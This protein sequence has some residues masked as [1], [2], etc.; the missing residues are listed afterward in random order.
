MDECSGAAKTQQ[1]CI[2]PEKETALPAPLAEVQALTNLTEGW[3]TFAVRWMEISEKL[4]TLAD[5]VAFSLATRSLPET[6]A[7][8]GSRVQSAITNS[9][10]EIK[11]KRSA[12]EE[13]PEASV[14]T[15]APVRRRSGGT[16][17]TFSSQS[18]GYKRKKAA[19][20]RGSS[21]SSSVSSAKPRKKRRCGT[22][23]ASTTGSATGTT[24]RSRTKRATVAKTRK[25]KA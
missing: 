21:W 8:P 14:M 23:R 16:L 7:I 5:H 22:C 3:L 17:N 24:R 25:K 9:R 13:K 6:S 20:F 4:I 12:K 10:L 2:S 1:Q 19:V 15:A 18:S 11:R